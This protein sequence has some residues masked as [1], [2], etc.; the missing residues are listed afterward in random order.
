MRHCLDVARSHIS[1]RPHPT[2]ATAAL[3]LPRNGSTM[4]THVGEGGLS[5]RSGAR[6]PFS[7]RGH[8]QKSS[9]IM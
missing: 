4:T 2:R 1:V 3:Y 5:L 9:F 8:G 6:E 7:N